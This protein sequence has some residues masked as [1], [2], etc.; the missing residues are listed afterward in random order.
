MLGTFRLGDQLTIEPASITDIHAGDVICF[1]GSSGND[2][3]VI[4]AH[5]VIAVSVAGLFT[6]GDNNPCADGTLVTA[7]NLVG[8]VTHYQRNGVTHRVRGGR[9]DLLRARLLHARV[10][11]RNWIIRVWR[12][13]YVWLRS[14]RVLARFWRPAIT[15]I[16]LTTEQGACVKYIYRGQTIARWYPR[17]RQF[18]C[19]K[20]YDLILAPPE[21]TPSVANRRQLEAETR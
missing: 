19:V 17:T 12:P 1:P 7:A 8:K 18:E 16:T 2:A 21:D 13:A 10:H 3:Q 9:L 6:R 15:Q 5:R 20:P 4:C 11:L 14:S